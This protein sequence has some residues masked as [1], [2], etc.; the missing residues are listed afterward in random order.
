MLPALLLALAPLSQTPATPPPPADPVRARLES[1]PRHHEWVD[2]VRGERR[3]RAF[4]A[5][6][7]SSA[8][9]PAVLVIHEN[10]GLTDWERSVAD[11]LA[12]RGYLAIVPDLLSGHAPE[13]RGTDGFE[14]RDA[15]TR[16]IYALEPAEVTADLRATAS[17][18]LSL[19]AC[20]G[21]LACV[22]F[23][24]GGA[25]A[26][27]LA[28]DEPRL[29]ASFVFY[30]SAPQEQAQLARIG[31]PVYGFYGERDARINEGLEA[32]AV[33][34][35]ALDKRFEPEVFA[36]AGHG[37]LRA[38]EASDASPENRRAF[39]EGWQRLER[40]LAATTKR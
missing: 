7:E 11:R 28:A 10:K 13:G 27:E 18:V 30:G 24:W 12:E 6:P 19:S 37:F 39:V 16:A 29:A 17:H 15:A 21:T 33:A 5:F 25:R 23:C 8:K 31:C 2:V 9:A 20:D 4:L 35:K 36:G 1:S 26:F 34:M 40:L 14:S 22:G 3:V 32:T 38:G